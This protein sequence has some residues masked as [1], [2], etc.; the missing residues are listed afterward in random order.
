MEENWMGFPSVGS[1]QQDH[2]GFFDF[3]IGGGSPS[4]SKDCR[5]TDD[6]RSVS[7]SIAGVDVVRRHGGPDELLG[8]VV[9]LIGRL[10]TTEH[11][12]RIAS[13]I[14]ANRSK[15][16][17]S[18]VKCLVPTCRPQFSVVADQRRLQPRKRI[19]EPLRDVLGRF[20]RMEQYRI[21]EPSG[22]AMP[23]PRTA[24]GLVGATVGGH[25]LVESSYSNPP[26]RP[27]RC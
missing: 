4:G 20:H 26:R 15:P 11:G 19:A 13:V 16:C 21:A 24:V 12:E 17:R 3:G 9:H 10:G 2:V 1:P 25:A 7:S 23:N 5:Q 27:G 14:L 18:S 6:A 22:G 8:G